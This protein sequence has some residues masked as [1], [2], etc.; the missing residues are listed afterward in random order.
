MDDLNR[1]KGIMKTQEKEVLSGI[2]HVLSLFGFW[3]RIAVVKS[4]IV[5]SGMMDGKTRCTRTQH[6]D[7]SNAAP[8]ESRNIEFPTLWLI[9]A[10]R[11]LFSKRLISG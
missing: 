1:G 8:V 3:Y 4:T 7:P 6:V 2:D 11:K 9:R 10:S 5:N